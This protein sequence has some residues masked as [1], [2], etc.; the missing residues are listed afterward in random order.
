MEEECVYKILILGDTCTDKSLFLMRYM[1]KTFQDIHM[2]TIGLDYRLKTMKL[3]KGKN[4]KLQI[5]VT[6]GQDRFRAITKNYYKGSHGIILLYDV[7]NLQS[8]E[9][10]KSW[11]NQIREEA[12]P[13]VVIYLVGSKIDLEEERKVTKKDGEKLA[14][15]F[16]L[17][18]LEASGK[19]GINVNEVLD[20]I[21]ERIDDVYG[22]L[23][24][25]KTVIYKAKKKGFFNFLNN[26][27]E[28]NNN[29]AKESEKQEK[30]LEE[31]D[32]CFPEDTYN[33]F[34]KLKKYLDF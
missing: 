11:I 6:A 27:T 13:N 30:K 20:D 31:I 21:V 25:K 14:E 10:I 15:E 16:G 8:F 12:S 22:N 2:A 32:K 17:P 29:K 28:K 23:S 4:I 5:W 7:T 33:K 3:K 24:K 19:S 9:N 26:I 1:D 18:F 34:P